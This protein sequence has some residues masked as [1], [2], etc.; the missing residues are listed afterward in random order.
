MPL[1]ELDHALIKEAQRLPELHEAGGVER[2]VS[3]D[4][5]VWFKVKTSRW[6]GAATRLAETE[7]PARESL[8]RIAPWW[9]GAAGYR[10]D[11]DPSDFYASL[12]AAAQQDGKGRVPASVCSDRWLPADWDWTR[13]TLE[14][15][16]AWEFEVRKAVCGLIARSLRT[17]RIYEANFGHHTVRV[18][19]RGADGET[20]LAVGTENISDTKVFAAIINAVPGIEGDSWMPE[21][22]GVMGIDPE[23]AEIIWSTILPPPVAAR[24]LEEYPEADE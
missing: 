12:T 20:Y 18:L 9:L 13:L 23:P 19:A 17:G 7:F 5:R 24:L 10:R 6:R 15:A 4:D 16:Y 11:G 2:I 8:I 21:P 14:I 3:L 1:S 22:G